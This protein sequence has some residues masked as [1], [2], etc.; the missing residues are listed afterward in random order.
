M[1]L[2]L[3][4]VSHHLTDGHAVAHEKVE[5]GYKRAKR[6]PMLVHSECRLGGLEDEMSHL[7]QDALC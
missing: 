5:G 2:L 3:F 7:T 4:A 1:H 6:F